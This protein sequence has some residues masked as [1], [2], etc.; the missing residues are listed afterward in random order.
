[1]N[2]LGGTRSDQLAS[3]ELLACSQFRNRMSENGLSA[4]RNAGVNIGSAVV[5]LP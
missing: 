4:W 1:M 2:A 3:V 5:P